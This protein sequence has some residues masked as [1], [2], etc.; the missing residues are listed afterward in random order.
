M[1]IF[2]PMVEIV[3][4]LGGGLLSHPKEFGRTL[5]AI[6]AAARR[7]RLLVVPG[8]GPFADAVRRV[9]RTTQLSDDAAHWMAV[10]AMDQYAHLIASRL[11]R[12]RVERV[13]TLV[14]GL[15]DMGW[16][17]IIAPSQ[18]LQEADPLPHDWSV[19]SD[20]IAAWIAGSIG[21]T[22]LL[23][24]KP[25]GASGASVVDSYFSQALP[26]TLS[27]AIFAADQIER[28]DSILDGVGQAHPP[29]VEEPSDLLPQGH[30][31]KQR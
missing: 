13:P 5:G 23:L 17:P 24:I 8:G 11:Q 20:S 28:I 14:D 26:P 21:A 2:N 18:W 3:V 31:H 15:I 6:S 7:R 4:K 10:L 29:R 30:R 16:I 1:L 12:G 25:P 19:T 22:Q 9:Y 27:H